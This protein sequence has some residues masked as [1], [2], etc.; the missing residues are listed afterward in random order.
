M[1]VEHH[2]LSSCSVNCGRHK[3]LWFLGFRSFLS[4]RRGKRWHVIWQHMSS[5]KKLML[6]E[7]KTSGCS[8]QQ[9]LKR[10]CVHLDPRGWVGFYSVQIEKKI[11]AVR[12]KNQRQEHMRSV[13][14]LPR[15]ES[16][17]TRRFWAFLC[18][19]T[20]VKKKKKA[21]GSKWKKQ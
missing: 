11:R 17:F 4:R 20:V 1:V 3:D 15:N 21:W 14:G 10:G 18:Y 12:A 5:K 8:D 13:Q 19:E 7:E 9:R 6:S 16:S 2:L